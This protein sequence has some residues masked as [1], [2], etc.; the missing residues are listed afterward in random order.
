MVPRITSDNSVASW[1]FPTTPLATPHRKCLLEEYFPTID[2]ENLTVS[3]LSSEAEVSEQAK[4]GINVPSSSGT[5]SINSIRTPSTSPPSSYT[6][7][8]DSSCEVQEKPSFESGP[9]IESFVSIAENTNQHTAVSSE[10]NLP[11]PSPHTPNPQ[12]IESSTITPTTLANQQGLWRKIKNNVR[13]SSSGSDVE[14]LRNSPRKEKGKFGS[15]FSS[16]SKSLLSSR[17]HANGMPTC[18]RFSTKGGCVNLYFSSCRRRE[19]NF[20]L[21]DL[22]A[23]FMHLYLKFL[24]T[25][26]H[27]MVFIL[28]PYAQVQGIER[29]RKCYTDTNHILNS[30]EVKSMKILV[31]YGNGPSRLHLDPSFCEGLALPDQQSRLNVCRRATTR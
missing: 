5:S 26:T 25:F 16:A 18:F 2:R 20:S 3:F 30:N 29:C 14:G 4:R 15:I 7:S 19:I 10:P 1:D 24:S 8:I 27:H 31:K 12:L 23:Q 6:E 11:T 21:R 13:P 9:G 28:I 22:I 17:S